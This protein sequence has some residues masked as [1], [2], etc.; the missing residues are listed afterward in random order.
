[1]ALSNPHLSV[2]LLNSVI[3]LILETG[4]FSVEQENFNFDICNL[5]QHTVGKIE[6]VLQL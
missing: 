2:Q 6:M 1:M 4:N 3:D 5:D